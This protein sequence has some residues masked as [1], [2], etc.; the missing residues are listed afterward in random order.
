MDRVDCVV[1][2]AG[3]IGLAVAARLSSQG[4]EVV[5]IEKNLA[6]GA[7]TSSRN[8]EVIHAGIYYPRNSLKAQMCVR[9][10]DLI[11]EFCEQ[12]SIPY[13]NCGK[14]IVATSRDQIS[15]LDRYARQAINNGVDDL[16]WLDR[17]AIYELEPEI[18]GI[19]GLLSPSTGILDS[20]DFMLKLQAITQNNG[21]VIAFGEKVMEIKSRPNRVL[22]DNY[23]LEAEWIINSAGLGAADL[24]SAAVSTTTP[25]FAKGHY[26][27]YS[28]KPFS[29]L[30][31]PTAEAGGLGV[32]VTLDI[33]GN[34]RFG[35]DVCWVDALD[36]KFER[37]RKEQFIDAI[38][39]YYPNLDEGKLAPSYVGIRPKVFIEN[40]IYS[41]FIISSECD[42][43]L[44][45]RIDLLGIE[46]PGLTASLAL[47]EYVDEIMSNSNNRKSMTEI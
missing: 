7:E 43:G 26:F 35:P 27:S 1:V 39:K 5:I 28:G 6:I 23:E 3:I 40:K 15:V 25:C 21:G 2:G 19:A 22:T 34:V 9:G 24:A 45:G 33:A 46:S 42:H 12:W 13:K 29:R 17:T 31:Y 18:E 38:K 20:H 14:I 10:R 4:R 8:S 16:L 36:Y 47:S 37:D 11:Y 44:K 41:D 32:H 30:V